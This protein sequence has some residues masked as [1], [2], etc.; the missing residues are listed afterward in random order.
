MKWPPYL[1]KLH[2]DDGKHCFGL[3]VP[4]FIIGPIVLVF[5]LAIFII[6]LAFAILAFV[7]SCQWHWLRSVLMGVPAVYNLI[8]SLP[9]VKVNINT[10]DGKVDISVY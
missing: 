2:F 8:S 5:L 1:M 6:L 3:W 9:G 10:T 4:L 7:F